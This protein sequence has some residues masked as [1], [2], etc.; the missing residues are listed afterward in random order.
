MAQVALMRTVY[1]SGGRA[2]RGRLQYITRDVEQA[3][4]PAERQLRYLREGREDL[5]YTNTRNLPGWAQG[6]ACRYFQEAERSE[7]APGAEKRYRGTAFEE[8]KILLPQGLGHAANMD[9]MRDLLEVIAGKTLPCTYAFHDPK[10]LDGTA[11]QPHLHLLISARQTDEHPRTPTQHFKRYNARHPA[12]GGA[13]K[14]P[15]FRHKGAVKAW[16]VTISDV[17]NV[18]LE[19]AGLGDRVHPDSLKDRGI[20]RQPEPKLLPSESRVYRNTGVV[21]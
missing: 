19:R 6:D 9:L 11:H 8:W 1:K 13:R 15:A 10:T 7:R 5:V 18:H 2:A 14:D 3:Q 20:D 17:I 16:R 21:S 12:R 4:T